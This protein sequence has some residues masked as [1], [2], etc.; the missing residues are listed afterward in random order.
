MWFFEILLSISRKIL[1]YT[2]KVAYDF[3]IPS[4]IHAFILS[5]EAT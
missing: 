3:Y 2:L 4:T 1:G 5:F